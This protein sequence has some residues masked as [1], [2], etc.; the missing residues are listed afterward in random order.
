MTPKPM[1]KGPSKWVLSGVVSFG[2]GCGDPKSPG[3]YARVSRFHGWISKQVAADPPGFVAV[4]SPGTDPDEDFQCPPPTTR[5]PPPTTPP[6]PP[7]VKP[8]DSLFCGGPSAAHFSYLTY[9][10]TVALVI[11]GVAGFA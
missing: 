7:P 8:C 1:G 4:T 3:V 6:P 5:P 10:V 2:V 9:V 11:H